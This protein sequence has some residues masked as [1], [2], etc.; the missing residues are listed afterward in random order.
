MAK[1]FSENASNILHLL[2]DTGRDDMTYR[3]IADALSLGG[4]SVSGV[5]T[6]LAKKGLIVRSEPN[7]SGMKTISLT[8]AGQTVDA[9]AEK[10]EE[11]KE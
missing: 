5:L 8:E 2:Q 3:D 11:N 6:S 4:R 1:V 7:A 9:D 10:P